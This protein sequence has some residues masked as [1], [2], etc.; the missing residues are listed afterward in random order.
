MKLGGLD[1][2]IRQTVIMFAQMKNEI[3]QCI[4]KYGADN[5]P[6]APQVFT[7]PHHPGDGNVHLVQK[8]FKGAFE[9]GL[10]DRRA[11]W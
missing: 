5:P 3:N 4:E 2:D 10:F 9:V 7:I 11:E 1:A 8:V 6:P